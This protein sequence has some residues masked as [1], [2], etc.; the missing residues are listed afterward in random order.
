MVDEVDE[1]RAVARL[2]PVD[3]DSAAVRADADVS[4]RQVGVDERAQ[5]ALRAEIVDDTEQMALRG[6]QRVGV[7]AV[8]RC[9]GLVGCHVLRPLATPR[10]EIQLLPRVGVDSREPVRTTAEVR[11]M[12]VGEP[13]GDRHCQRV[14]HIRLIAIRRPIMRESLIDPAPSR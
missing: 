13:N 4:R 9:E 10:V 12:E 14:R 7:M 11:G 6:V 2:L 5:G 1:Q 3:E 8:R